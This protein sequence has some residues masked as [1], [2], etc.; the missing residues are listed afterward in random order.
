MPEL[1]DKRVEKLW[2]LVKEK[3]DHVDPS[4]DF[5]HILR[6][7]RM[8]ERIGRVEGAD[9][10]ILLPAALLHDVV[11]VPKNHPDRKEA[12]KM[13]AKE[14]SGILFHLGYSDS[15]IE[16]ISTV[17]V[18]HSFSLGK[19][20]SSIE[21]AIL[22][23]ADRLDAL[24]AIGI[25]RTVSCGARF[26]ARYYDDEDPFAI[27]RALDDKSFTLDHFY[28]KLFQLA[29]KMNTQSAKTQALARME[30]M[31]TFVQQLKEEIGANEF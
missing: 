15:E 13:A 19:A 28:V 21:S 17:I 25:M 30:F 16:R 26:E 9:L 18:E 24:G 7:V 20:P 1:A 6:V 4:H 12:S 8:C 27:N 22:Q 10:N 23:D 2:T 5:N 14:A 11:N 29:D 31:K 3:Y